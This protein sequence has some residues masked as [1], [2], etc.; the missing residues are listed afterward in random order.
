MLDHKRFVLWKLPW[1]ALALLLS[2]SACDMLPG[3]ATQ[4]IPTDTP[5]P[6][7]ETPEVIRI[8]DF[9]P[10]PTSSPVATFTPEESTGPIESPTSIQPVSD[11]TDTGG[12][13]ALSSPVN[14][15]ELPAVGWW[16]FTWEAH[17]DA[18]G[19]LLQVVAPNG[20]VLSIETGETSV[21]RALEAFSS[22]G[23]Y[24]WTVTAMGSDGEEICQAGPH[25]FFK[26]AP[27]DDGAAS[28]KNK[29]KDR[30]DDDPHCQCVH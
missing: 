30:R 16:T 23:V 26:P 27:G 14:G 5:E 28:S 22:G 19:Y 8:L 7:T 25:G 11:S 10:T 29:E 3:S 1:L 21:T 17:P 4:V 6:P 18:L 20:W 13:L 15:A 12:C 2:I 9:E 24:V